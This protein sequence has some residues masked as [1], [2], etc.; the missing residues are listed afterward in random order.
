MNKR[1]IVKCEGCKVE[2]LK[3]ANQNARNGLYWCS[4]ECYLLTN[5]EYKERCKVIV[6]NYGVSRRNNKEYCDRN[7]KL[8]K[9]Y[10]DNA[11]DGYIK[12]LIR[13]S[14]GVKINDSDLIQSYREQLRVKRLL[15]Q[16]KNG[17][18]KENIKAS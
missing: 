11:V 7:K 4:H 6:Y 15:K 8:L 3:R 13:Q 18:S 10:K 5:T 14:I 2:F 16:L 17:T 1:L 12:Q 9:T